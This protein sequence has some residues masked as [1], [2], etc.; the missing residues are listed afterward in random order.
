MAR[1]RPARL[2]LALLGLSAPALLVAGTPSPSYASSSV[3]G[4]PLADALGQDC[5]APTARIYSAKAN[6]GYQDLVKTPET[7]ARDAEFYMSTQAKD[8]DG[9]KVTFTCRL[10]RNGTVVGQDWQDC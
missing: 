9:D 7:T 10:E 1:R 4:S 8:P 6:R 3:C 5:T 2:V